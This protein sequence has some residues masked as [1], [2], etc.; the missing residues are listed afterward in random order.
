M[1]AFCGLDFGTSNSTI[2]VVKNNVYEL[3]LLENNSPIIRSAVF[4]DLEIQ[5]LIFGQKAIDGYL[6]GVPGRLL[7]SL[8]SVLGSSLMT[9]KTYVFNEFVP[10]TNILAQFVNYL[11]IKAEENLNTPITQVVLGRPVYFHD[12]NPHKDAL[13][14]NTLEMIAH[15]LGFKEVSFQYE[16]IAAALS[17]EATIKKEQLALIVDMGGGTSDFTVIRL[18]T[19]VKNTDRSKD[20]LSNSGIHIAGTDF[21]KKLSLNSVMPLLGMGSMMKGSSS[22]IVFPPGCY[23]DLA[24]WHL[25]TGLYDAK[26]I[27]HIR[28]MLSVSYEKDLIERFIAVLENKAGHQI[29]NAVEIAKKKLSDLSDYQMD[30]SFIENN[31]SLVVLRKAFNDTISTELEKIVSTIKKTIV[32]AGV[33]FS[34]IDAVFYTGGSTKIPLVREKINVLLP[35]AD[36]IQ[37][38]AFGSVGLGL[39]IDA[40]RKYG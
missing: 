26:N 19:N 34:D 37:G 6:E 12:D 31:L 13:A 27:A 8:K 39:T 11:K 28:T 1:S 18:H 38:D 33:T 10:Y 22:D 9:E 25:L 14:Q 3:V 40:K 7:M 2:G 16:P 5:K 32:E 24:T 15:D 20:V 30:L 21:D 23:H 36:L 35:N 29:L 17:Y 4:C